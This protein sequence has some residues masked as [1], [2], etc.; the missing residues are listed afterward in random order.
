MTPPPSYQ[1]AVTLHLTAC[2]AVSRN[3]GGPRSKWQRRISV[4]E[5]QISSRTCGL[6]PQ[7]TREQEIPESAGWSKHNPRERLRQVGSVA[8]GASS[9]EVCGPQLW[10]PIL[11]DPKCGALPRQALRLALSG[12]FEPLFYL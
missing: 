3:Q 10:T 12:A 6:S 9:E 4:L 5:R 7:R 1:A 8:C 11:G 2:L